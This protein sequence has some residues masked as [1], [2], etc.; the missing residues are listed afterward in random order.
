MTAASQPAVVF[1]NRTQR[2]RYTG[3]KREDVVFTHLLCRLVLGFVEKGQSKP[4]AVSDRRIG[5]EDG[6]R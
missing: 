3:R 4:P 6:Y 1:G 5:Y 2:K